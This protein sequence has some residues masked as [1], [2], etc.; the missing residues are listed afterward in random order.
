MVQFIDDHRDVS[1]RRIWFTS[2][3]SDVVR[4]ISS[5]VILIFTSLSLATP[6]TS[7]GL[8]ALAR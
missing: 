6:L 5:Q 2:A 7:G 8:M 3:A 4:V 1:V